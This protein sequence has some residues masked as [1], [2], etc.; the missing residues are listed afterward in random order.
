MTN[1]KDKSFKAEV[2]QTAKAYIVRG[3]HVFPVHSIDQNGECTCGVTNCQSA[4]KHPSV[5]NGF[6]DASR[7][8]EQIE[9]WFGG[10]APLRNIGIATGQISDLTIIDVDCGD[11]KVGEKSYQDLIKGHLE[12]VTL[13]S[14]TG[15]GGFH[16]Y[17]K[18]NSSLKTAV[19]VLGKNIDCRS[20][21]GY[22]LAPP[23]RHLS[24]NPYCWLNP[25]ESIGNLPAHF[26]VRKETRGRPRNST[27][28]K[29]KH[30]L[31]QVESMLQVIP[32]VERDLWRNVGVIL[33]REFN[34]SDAAWQV[35]LA[36][37]GKDEKGRSRNH[38]EIMQ[39]A[40]YI[41][42]LE[43]AEKELSIGTIVKLA[44]EGGWSPKA[45][46]VPI[47]NFVFYMPTNSFIYR[48][49]SAFGIAA[50]AVDAA[51]SP[52]NETGKLV[53]ASEWLKVNQLA[54]S[55]TSDPQIEEDYLKGHDCRNGE[56][57]EVSGAA[58]FNTYRKPTIEF[59][60][61]KLA[62]PF[63]KHC[64]KVFN[65]SSAN[66]NQVPDY[67]Q[68]FLYMAHRVQKPWEKPRFALM[69][70]GGQG[71]GKDTAIEFCSPA[72]GSW[73]VSN[74][75]PSAFEQ[76]FNEF[77]ASTLV[78]I[79]EA[80]NLH[81]MSKWAFNERTKV[82]ISGSPDTCTINPKYSPKYSVR[83]FCGTVITTNHLDSGIYI[84]QDDR[85]YD[86]IECATLEQMGL[87]DDRVRREY[88][89]SLWAWFLAG[90]SRHIAAYLSEK[91]ISSFSPNN[92]RK[93]AAH[94]N[95]IQAGRERHV[96]LRDI[97]E[98]LNNPQFVSFPTIRIIAQS[99]GEDTH[100]PTFPSRAANALTDADYVK[101]P[102]PNVADG[103]WRKAGFPKSF[104][105]YSKL[106]TPFGLDPLPHVKAPGEE[107]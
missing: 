43:P 71:V 51:V 16:L 3:W 40:F 30:S 81:E 13:I 39:E 31:A 35:Y 107:F 10:D 92:G 100:A 93:T 98:Q 9:S 63:L 94:Q 55:I 60:D 20:D 76:Q 58:L 24:G 45:G 8:I 28:F 83:M 86:V 50:A 82:L 21:G 37:A 84:P 90:G 68:F 57:I 14:S 18:F 19:N 44:L 26:A 73:N 85:R 46:E 77:A 23:S 54:T 33:G 12:F 1:N 27:T 102:N 61:A 4:A 106:G 56:V 96:W 99:H 49:T 29:G 72:I 75:D 25:Q 62:E 89:T 48:P 66:E 80:A 11:G 91:D 38:S 65:Q 70:A 103:R 105:V 15:G 47:E 88:F 22:V 78:R 97:I 59:G 101:Y 5:K 53:K 6:K 17:F 52:I 95:V 79:S 87:A 2:L 7:D 36:W 67:E 104:H 69:I 42:S 34:R 74:I 41:I 32:S 64:K